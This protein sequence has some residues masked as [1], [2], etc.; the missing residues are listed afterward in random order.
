MVE[1]K[2]FK[3]DLDAVLN[4]PSCFQPYS[5]ALKDE[6]NLVLEAMEDSPDDEKPAFVP[7]SP[8]TPGLPTGPCQD[9]QTSPGAD[10]SSHSTGKIKARPILDASAIPLP[11]GESVNSAQLD[12]PD[13]HMLKISQIL[14]RLRT[15]KRFA[16]GDVS[17][18][19]FRLH[20]DPTTTSLTRVLF[21]RNGLGSE[22]DIYE[23]WSTVGGMGLKQ[24]TA[25][26]SHVRY[27][28]S[29]TLEDEM[30]A[31]ALQETYLDDVNNYE[32]IGECQKSEKHLGP[33]DDGILPG[34]EM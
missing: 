25:L 6:E 1:P 15:C 29:L 12:I 13:I 21:R 2:N 26:S 20:I 16:I 7:E 5:F 28:I 34:S 18:F 17:E 27:K 8:P 31:K 24:L 9:R 11:G 32:K 22:G 30:A 19:F 4:S 3:G 33:C 10:N 14:L 23:L